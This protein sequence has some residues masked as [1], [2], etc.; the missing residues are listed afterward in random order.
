MNLLSKI[1]NYFRFKS[2]S[3]LVEQYLS[4]SVDLVDLERRQK[5]LQNKQANLI[6][7]GWG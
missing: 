7:R 6:L 1:Y 3:E 5:L 2:D 4:E